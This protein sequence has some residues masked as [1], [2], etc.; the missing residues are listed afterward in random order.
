MGYFSK[1]DCLSLK[2]QS[3]FQVVLKRFQLAFIC[4]GFL[5][6]V[7]VG[8]LGIFFCFQKWNLKFH[9]TTLLGGIVLLHQNLLLW[10]LS[11]VK[12]LLWTTKAVSSVSGNQWSANLY[13][14]AWE[15]VMTFS[16]M[17]LL[18]LALSIS[19][20]MVCLLLQCSGFCSD[21]SSISHFLF[22]FASTWYVLRNFDISSTQLILNEVTHYR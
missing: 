15:L 17:K 5:L 22:N 14:H 2:Y 3:L 1:Y 21:F 9:F 13:F 11:E 8:K 19:T 18:Y 7:Q 16:I 6:S 20:K 12:M 10:F 4:F